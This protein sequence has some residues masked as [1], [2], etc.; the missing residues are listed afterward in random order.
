[1]NEAKFSLSTNDEDSY[2]TWM[3]YIEFSKAKAVYE[4]FVNNFGKV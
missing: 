4:G 3:I 1:M 2:E